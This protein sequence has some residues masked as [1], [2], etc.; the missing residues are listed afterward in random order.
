M[1]LLCFSYA[2]NEIQRVFR[3]FLGRVK[4]SNSLH[5]K[6]NDR[7]LSLFHYLSIQIQKSF[8]GYYSRKYKHC[9]AARKKYCKTLLEEGAKIR[10]MMKQYSLDQEEVGFPLFITSFVFIIFLSQ[11]ENYE[12]QTKKEQ[13]FKTLA[14]NLHHLLST[15]HISGI[16]NPAFQF[17]EVISP[18]YPSVAYLDL[19]FPDT[20]DEFNASRKSHPWGS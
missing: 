20:D 18:Y 15:N 9:Q 1:I 7:Q 4:S 19:L 11:R 8:R 12:A 13:E 2:A 3:G 6:S 10:N 5:D 16:Y 17:L 14:Q